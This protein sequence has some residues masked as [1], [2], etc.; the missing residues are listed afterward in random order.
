M[1]FLKGLGEIYNIVKTQIMLMKPLL[2]I[3]RVFSLVLKQ[4]RQLNKNI[5]VEKV[6]IHNDG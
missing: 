2:S 5:N 1:C 3:N 6:F 4:E